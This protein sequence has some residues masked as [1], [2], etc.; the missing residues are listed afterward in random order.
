MSFSE[1][2]CFSLLQKG[3]TVYSLDWSDAACTSGLPVIKFLGYPSAV[4]NTRE[5]GELMAKYDN[6]FSYIRCIN[7]QINININNDKYETDLDT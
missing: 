4:Q 2:A 6:N 7:W 3:V 5:I 1:K